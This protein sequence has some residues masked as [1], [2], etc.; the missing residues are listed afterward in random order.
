MKILIDVGHGK[1]DLGASYHGVN[2]KDLN[3]VLASLIS[4][5]AVDYDLIVDL[6]RCSDKNL[7]G[8]ER[9][10]NDND[11]IV[12]IHHNACAD[13]TANG[14]EILYKD[15]SLLLANSLLGKIKYSS[16]LKNRGLK[17]RK[18]LYLLNV[19]KI[20]TVIVECGF[21]SNIDELD[22]LLLPRMQYDM[23]V[24]IVEGLVDYSRVMGLES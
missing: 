4:I 21:I 7:S 8:P 9:I 24:A 1:D 20:P 17:L 6:T 19:S 22:T 14:F 16:P 5:V 3:L 11:V 12:S 15:E 23:A 13:E 10:D 18:S 2:E